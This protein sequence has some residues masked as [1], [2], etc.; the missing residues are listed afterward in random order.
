MKIG[1]FIKENKIKTS[2]LHQH[3]ILTQKI[4]KN[5]REQV[6]QNWIRKK[7]IIAHHKLTLTHYGSTPKNCLAIVQLAAH[8]SQ[9]G[10]EL[11][12]LTVH[13]TNCNKQGVFLGTLGQKG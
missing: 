11:L 6:T 4:P 2:K 7:N 13:T 12:N 10:L 1:Y 5:F 3:G 8:K 9:L